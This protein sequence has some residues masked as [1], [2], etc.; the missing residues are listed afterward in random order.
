MKHL[1]LI[2]KLFLREIFTR[3]QG[4]LLGIT[5]SLINPLLMLGIY[6][7][8]F[9]EIFKMR[10]GGAEED[11]VM[12]AIMVFSGMIVLSFFTEVL[13]RAPSLI[14]HNVNYVKKVVFPLEVLS[15]VSIAT[16]IFQVCINLTILLIAML[17]I[18][19]TFS[20]TA[21]FL[22]FVIAPLILLALGVSWGLSAIG[23]YF[24]DVGELVTALTTVLVFLS[25][26]FYPMSAVPESLRHYILLNPL[27]FIIEQIRT[28][29]V[30][31]QMPNWLGLFQYSLV[32]I[33]VAILGYV[34]FEK[35]RRG[36]ADV[37]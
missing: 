3:Y 19:G 37:L 28:V 22:P 9:S 17:L 29:V 33:I 7:V 24:R 2:R 25:P 27:T 30:L 15:I 13:S 34:L 36:F 10:W 23:V 5:W 14:L 21:I 16:A 31:G 35:S 18:K 20:L 32:A 11:K 12:F 8:V 4:S 1:T 26:V 6:T